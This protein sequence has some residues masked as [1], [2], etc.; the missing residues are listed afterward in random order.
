MKDI[1]PIL[2]DYYHKSVPKTAG[3]TRG[4]VITQEGVIRL[5]PKKKWMK[6][7]A[8]Q[9][10]SA[11][12]VEFSWQA[13]FKMASIFPGSVVDAYIDGAGRLDAK[14]LGFIPVA[15]ARGDNVDQSEIQRY[16]AEIPWCPAAIVENSSLR[17]KQKSDNCVC[18]WA[19]DEKN[20]VD[21]VFNSA[22]DICQANTAARYQGEKPVP[23]QGE[24]ADYQTYEGVRAPSSGVVQWNESNGAF[25]Y[26]QGKLTSLTL[27]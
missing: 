2:L 3:G 5:S 19:F 14:I 22:G 12:R 1:P 4:T 9:R 11:K 16:L 26:W 10:I 13:K 24:F 7:K 18:V 27:T 6:F 17:F 25:I 23:W 20:Y 15:H 8:T 21:L